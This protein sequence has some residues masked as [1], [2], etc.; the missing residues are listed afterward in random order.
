M[1]AAKFAD[2]V[3]SALNMTPAFAIELVSLR[4][5]TLAMNVAFPLILWLAKLN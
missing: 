3:L 5:V 1:T 2:A 4:L